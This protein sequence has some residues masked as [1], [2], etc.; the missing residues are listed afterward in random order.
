MWKSKVQFKSRDICVRGIGNYP[1][2]DLLEHL[3]RCSV[4]DPAKIYF[5]SKLSYVLFC[6]PT[7]K[8]ETWIAN[9]WG[10]S[11]SKPP[12]PI[13]MMGQSET[14]SYQLDHIYYTLF[15]RC[16][17]LLCLSPATA[18]CTIKQTQ[19][20]FPETNR[21]TLDFLHPILLCWIT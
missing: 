18:T 7:H 12:G 11:N 4:C 8:N 13:I 10:T 1:L 6:N 19:N 5:R 17:A 16:T 2:T 9:R 3:Q 21:Q 14:L 15:S 20:H